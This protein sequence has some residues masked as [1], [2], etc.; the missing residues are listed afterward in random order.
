MLNSSQK[1][2]GILL[3]GGRGSRLAPMTNVVSKQLLPVYDKPMI[4][5]P[6]VTLMQANIRDVLLIATPE[7]LSGYQQL[8][9]TGKQWGIQLHYAEQPSPDGL[10]QAFK[11][12]A[13]FLDQASVM[14]LLG[15]NVFFGNAFQ[16]RLA[17]VA[18]SP[19]GATVF[20]T[21]HSQP[22]NYGVVELG[23]SQEI[24]SL[25][26]KPP[27]PKSNQVITGAYIFDSRV[28]EFAK[29]LRPSVRGET[30]MIDLLRCYQKQGELNV[31]S[32]A[33]GTNWFDAGT[34]QMLLEASLAIVTTQ[35]EQGLIG[36]PHRTAKSK[37]WV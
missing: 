15:D 19:S 7:H 32:L 27:Q 2:K 6:L 21:P 10:P 1:M 37:E 11:I 33:D 29:T 22:S 14:L 17:Q 16:N 8:L 13:D 18:Q 30:E 5:Y 28:V 3:A 36:C 23:P 34:P 9:G 20:S 24:I 25:E 12:G 4:Y 26:E 31:E 35:R